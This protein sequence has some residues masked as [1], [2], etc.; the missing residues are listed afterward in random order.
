MTQRNKLI[1]GAVVVLVGYYLY[2]RSRKM[3]VVAEL[4]A[5]EEAIAKAEAQ[6]L[7]NS[8]STKATKSLLD[9]GGSKPIN[10]RADSIMV[11]DN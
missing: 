4:K 10:F 9:T 8:P 11:T 6:V 3:R 7:A 1:V 5:Q 2:D